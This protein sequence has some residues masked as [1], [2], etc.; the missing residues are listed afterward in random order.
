MRLLLFCIAGAQLHAHDLE[1]SWRQL[2]PVVVVEC[3]Y[4]GT[5][6][7]AYAAV[8]IFSPTDAKSDFQNGRTD[9]QGRFS[10]Y[11]DAEGDWKFVVDDELGH[12]V[13]AEIAIQPGTA[14]ESSAAPS[15]WLTL[16][17]GLGI[18]VG[19]TGGLYGWK[20]RRTR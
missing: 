5:D 8:E 18:I 20:A 7:A 9:A 11:P 2:G 12:R 17:A 4:G 15:R 19:L 1:V 16:L 13:E 14:A 10:F 3:R 6:P